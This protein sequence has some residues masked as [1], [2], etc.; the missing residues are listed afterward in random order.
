MTRRCEGVRRMRKRL[1]SAEQA[2]IRPVAPILSFLLYL[3]G[4]EVRPCSLRTEPESPRS[5]FHE[6]LNRVR[7]QIFSRPGWFVLEIERAS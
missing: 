4:H 3:P 6:V 5:I 1:Q 2:I 7:E